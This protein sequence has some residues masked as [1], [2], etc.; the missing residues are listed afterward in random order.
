MNVRR[1]AQVD[2]SFA[3]IEPSWILRGRHELMTTLSGLEVGTIPRV[4][5]A[6][7]ETNLSETYLKASIVHRSAVQRRQQS[8][9]VR[10]VLATGHRPMAGS[11]A[12]WG[13]QGE[14]RRTVVPQG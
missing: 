3:K 7:Y 10:T 1:V 14:Q 4:W 11:K 8:I 5:H 6:R 12:A 9:Y 2:K 13:G